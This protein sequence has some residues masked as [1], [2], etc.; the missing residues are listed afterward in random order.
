MT[1]IFRGKPACECLAEWLPAFE[2]ELKAQGL[3]KVSIDIAQLIGTAQASAL[4]HSTGG[5]W[6]IWQTDWRVSAVARQM[7]A[8]AWPRVTG[9]FASNRHSHG[10]LVGCPHLHPQGLAQI[11][12]AYR[13]GDGLTGDAPDD[14]RLVA[15]LVRGR[16]WQQGVAWHRRQER[17]RKVK[18]VLIPKAIARLKE[19]R[20]EKKELQK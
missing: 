8:V 13:G 14:A 11:A 15:A 20:A 2:A 18:A 19:L 3:I 12:E 7:G 6:D 5:A 1:V 9:S 17:L 10:V 16:T 4:V